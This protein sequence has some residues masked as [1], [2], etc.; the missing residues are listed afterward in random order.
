KRG[1]TELV[2]PGVSYND[3]IVQQKSNNYLA[4][5]CFDKHTVGCSFLD[6]STGEFSV[7][8]GKAAYIDKLLQS[9]SPNEI[10]LCKKSYPDFIELFG[11]DYYTYTLD[12]WPYT[13]DY[14][15][16]LLLK[17]FEV[18]NLKGFG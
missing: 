11:S 12:E 18:R 17:H 16:D 1:V 5:I 15:R 6:I 10:I 14:A 13:G 4:S 3:N 7:A 9:F 2:T 8:Q